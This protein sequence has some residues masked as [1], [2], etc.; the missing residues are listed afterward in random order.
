MTNLTHFPGAKPPSPHSTLSPSEAVKRLIAWFP[1]ADPEPGWTNEAINLLASCRP[2]T[3]DRV[4]SIGRAAK[5]KYLPSIPQLHEWLEQA[6]QAEQVPSGRSL[7][8]ASVLSARAADFAEGW[9]RNNMDLIAEMAAKG[10]PLVWEA[11]LKEQAWLAAQSDGGSVRLSNSLLERWRGY[12]SAE[13]KPVPER[14]IMFGRVIWLASI[15]KER[16]A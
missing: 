9:M 3:L 5:P 4:L 6:T 2:S 11:F 12:P 16:V 10:L 15:G 14:V 13:P 1:K 7:P 8:E